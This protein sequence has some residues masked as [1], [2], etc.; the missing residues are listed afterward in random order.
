MASARRVMLG[1]LIDTAFSLP[2]RPFERR[3]RFVNSAAADDY[4]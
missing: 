1:K 2:D 4:M 3:P